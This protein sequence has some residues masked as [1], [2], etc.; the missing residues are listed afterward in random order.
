MKKLNDT[1]FVALQDEHIDAMAALAFQYEEAAEVEEILSAFDAQTGEASE[2]PAAV[3]RILAAA[4]EKLA[5]DEAAER[6]RTRRQRRK[7]FGQRFLEVAAC[8]LLLLAIAAPFAVANLDLIRTRFAELFTLES[9]YEPTISVEYRDKVP[10][11]FSHLRHADWGGL[12]FPAE[13]PEGFLQGMSHRDGRD[14]YIRYDREADGAWVVFAELADEP[15]PAEGVTGYRKIGGSGGTI[16]TRED[17]MISLTWYGGQRW[18]RLNGMGLTE[19]QLLHIARSVTPLKG[20]AALQEL[21]DASVQQL[22]VPQAYAGH[23]FPTELPAGFACTGVDDFFTFVSADFEDTQGRSFTFSETYGDLSLTDLDGGST[24]PVAVGSREGLLRRTEGS[25]RLALYWLNDYRMFTLFAD[26]MTEAEVITVAESVQLIDYATASRDPAVPTAT[27][28]PTPQPEYAPDEWSNPYVPTWMPENCTRVALLNASQIPGLGTLLW[29]AADDTPIMTLAAAPSEILHG[30]FIDFKLSMP[31][32][33]NGAAGRVL[34]SPMDTYHFD[35]DWQMG[36]TWFCLSGD[37][38]DTLL[39]LARSMQP[40]TAADI[41]RSPEQVAAV[42]EGLA[43]C[44]M[45]RMPE[46]PGFTVAGSY[47]W[48]SAFRVDFANPELQRYFSLCQLDPDVTLLHAGFA[49]QQHTEA[50]IT[51]GGREV[52]VYTV[53]D[54]DFPQTALLWQEEDCRYLLWSYSMSREALCEVVAGMR[55]IDASAAPATHTPEPPA[56]PAPTVP[57]MPGWPFAHRLSWIPTGYTLTSLTEEAACWTDDAGQTIIFTALGALSEENLAEL[58]ADA[59]TAYTASVRGAVVH[60]LTVTDLDTLARSYVLLTPAD[61]V[62]Y[63]IAV[64]ESSAYLLQELHR[65][66]EKMPQ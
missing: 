37:D 53:I 2:D 7:R 11:G 1:A 26:G 6:Q 62:W 52:T 29:Y 32:D 21:T 16:C 12:Y 56:T 28:E 45:L 34:F 23:F 57:F 50:Q 36:D 33:V 20:D 5:R 65:S 14:H 55:L 63:R 27:P 31:V 42:P 15:A 46:A 38:L 8:V 40:G 47:A 22:T 58:L 61:G 17:G 4:E 51:V 54:P 66:L 10:E 24:S 43:P 41:P 64:T 35:L 3:Q 18:F 39:R 48:G 25:D 30:G 19:A 49:T 13:M 59:D 44:R 9:D 60:D